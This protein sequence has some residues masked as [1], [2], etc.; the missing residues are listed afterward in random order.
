MRKRYHKTIIWSHC[1]RYGKKSNN[2]TSHVIRQQFLICHLTSLNI[3]IGVC[4]ELLTN[5]NYWGTD[6]EFHLGSLVFDMDVYLWLNP[7]CVTISRPIPLLQFN[8]KQRCAIHIVQYY[9][10]T[11]SY[12][13]REHMFPFDH[14][15]LLLVNTSA[16]P[17]IRE[18][19]Q[20]PNF[21]TQGLLVENQHVHGLSRFNIH[22]HLVVYIRMLL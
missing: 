16:G 12:W 22:P 18:V 7:S 8:S 15:E 1:K 11:S 17:H 13:D 21:Q 20:N 6:A 4:I 9:R 14:Y 10:G 5:A 19:Y 3:F 2:S